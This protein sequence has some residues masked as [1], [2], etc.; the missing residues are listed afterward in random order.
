MTAIIISLSEARA[1]WEARTLR[2]GK[3]IV[4]E[5]EGQDPSTAPVEIVVDVDPPV[6]PIDYSDC[7]AGSPEWKVR[8]QRAIAKYGPPCAD[9]C[10]V[11]LVVDLD[12]YEAEHGMWHPDVVPQPLPAYM[13]R[14][15]QLGLVYL[16][17][18]TGTSWC[19][20]HGWYSGNWS[21]HMPKDEPDAFYGTADAYV[22]KHVKEAAAPLIAKFPPFNPTSYD[23]D[24]V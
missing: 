17:A 13:V 2:P 3:Y 23:E 18:S 20:T 7:D 24:Y 8:L 9:N 16:D 11:E 4:V 5:D 21:F 10:E 15:E 14:K 12:E 22:P 6:V 19:Y 1:R